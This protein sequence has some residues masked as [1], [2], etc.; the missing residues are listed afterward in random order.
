[1]K[2]IYLMITSTV[3]KNVYLNAV[4]KIENEPFIR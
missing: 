2:F 4:C 3:F 1:M